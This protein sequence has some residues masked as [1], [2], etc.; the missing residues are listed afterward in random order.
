MMDCVPCAVADRNNLKSGTHLLYAA[1]A[2]LN[3]ESAVMCVSIAI[4]LTC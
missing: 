3:A 1:P 4:K 2:F